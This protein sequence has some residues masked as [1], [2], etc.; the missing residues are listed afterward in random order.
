MK[1]HGSKEQIECDVDVIVKP[2][3]HVRDMRLKKKSMDKKKYD[4]SRN[5]SKWK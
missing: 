2:N 1:K 4:K 5:E 3:K